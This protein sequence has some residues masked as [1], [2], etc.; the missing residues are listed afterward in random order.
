MGQ[1]KAELPEQYKTYKKYSNFNLELDLTGGSSD[2][3]VQLLTQDKVSASFYELSPKISYERE[4]AKK[5]FLITNFSGSYKDYDK[6]IVSDNKEAVKGQ[7]DLGFT[8][9]FNP[10]H[11]VGVTASGVYNKN[12]GLSFDSAGLDIEGRD[13]EYTQGFYE[14]YYSYNRPKYNIELSLNYINNKNDSLVQDFLQDG[15]IDEFKDDFDQTGAKLKLNYKLSDDLSTFIEPSYSK[16]NYKERAAKFSEGTSGQGINPKL[17]EDHRGVSLGFEYDDDFVKSEVKGLYVR[18]KDLQFKANNAITYG[19]ET[20]LSLPI[21][22]LFV[23]GGEYSFTQRDYDFFV[24]NPEVNPTSGNLR[25]D[26][27]QSYGVSVSKQFNKV[28]LK[29]KYNALNKDSN[30]K[31]F[32]STTGSQYDEKIISLGLNIKL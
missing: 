6:D 28:N 5:L 4:L 22:S 26:V 24:S 31:P 32:G 18:E 21:S 14:L 10:S 2:N 8:Y 29:L 15:S 1:T 19:I 3:P 13:I 9:F 23:L 27:D 30:Y 12:S 17:S 11:E 20:K 7:L 16:R 25:E